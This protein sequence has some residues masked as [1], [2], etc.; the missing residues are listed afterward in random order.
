MLTENVTR[1][2]SFVLF[3]MVDWLIS[4][5]VHLPTQSMPYG[6][7][8]TTAQYTKLGLRVQNERTTYVS[9][10]MHTCTFCNII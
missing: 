3:W 6:T 2:M 5:L 7:V 10:I 4:S 8:A 1:P 9:D